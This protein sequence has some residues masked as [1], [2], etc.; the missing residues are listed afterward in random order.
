MIVIPGE[1]EPGHVRLAT[2]EL[3]KRILIDQIE[4]GLRFHRLMKVMALR[5]SC[6]VEP[7]VSTISVRLPPR[8]A[9]D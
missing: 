7:G 8:L 6:G 3:F 1:P 4:S 9:K 5:R 2:S